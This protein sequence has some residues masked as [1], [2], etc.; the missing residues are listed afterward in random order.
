M[1]VRVCSNGHQVPQEDLKAC[2][3]CGASLTSATWTDA[4]DAEGTPAHEPAPR[5]GVDMPSTRAPAGPVLVVA[6]ALLSLL[7]WLGLAFAEAVLP[8]L[9]ATASLW[10]GGILT[11]IGVV[12]VGV[13]LGIEAARR[14]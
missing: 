13:T 5:P 1:Q 11:A 3:R 7:G 2:P 9:V 8:V 10:I 6:G 12:A 4:P 14:P